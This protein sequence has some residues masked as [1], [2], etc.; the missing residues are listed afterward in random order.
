MRRVC[1]L[2]GAGGTLG[3]AFCSR[4][5]ERY[6]IVAVYRDREPPPPT[7][8]AT[9][10][11]PLGDEPASGDVYAV[12]ADVTSPSG[13]A[14]VVDIALARHQ[15]VDLVVNAAAHAVWA[16]AVETAA[17]LDS[18][19]R[20]F[21]TNVLAP[22]RLAVELARRCWRD[23]PATNRAR[24]RN[25]VNVSSS[26]GVYVYPGQFHSVY[27]ATKAAL[28]TLTI[29]LAEEFAT[30]GVRVNAVAP[31]SFPHRIAIAEVLGDITALDEGTDTGRIVVRTPG[32]LTL[33]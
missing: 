20:A 12:H 11:D 1:L 17:L 27:A 28:N 10:V 15:S 6:D 32:E 14:R 4:L 16:P 22:L 9:Y 19:D 23:D 2:T 26:A 21:A 29:H 18:A 8:L 25:V 31:D 30:F 24:N 13:V 5:A 3:S 7:Q 33:I